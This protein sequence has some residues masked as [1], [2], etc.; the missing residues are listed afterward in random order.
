MPD[1]TPDITGLSI[2]MLGNFCNPAI[3]H[4]AW[5][6]KY[7][8]LPEEE[9]QAIEEQIILPDYA[10]FNLAWVQVQVNRQRLQMGTIDPPSVNLVR[11]LVIGTFRILSHTPVSALGINHDYHYRQVSAERWRRIRPYAI[12]PLVLGINPPKSWNA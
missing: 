9:A 3:F 12:S 10:Q 6:T 4:S 5:F 2:V 1:H 8:L 11:D 7:G